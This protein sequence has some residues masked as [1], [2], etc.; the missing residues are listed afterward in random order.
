M[1]ANQTPQAKFLSALRKMAASGEAGFEGFVRDCLQESL[2]VRFCLM[3]SGPQDGADMRSDGPANLLQVAVEGKRYGNATPLPTEQIQLKI[4]S[5]AQAAAGLDLWVLATTRAISAT[6]RAKFAE[7]GDGQGV[8]TA[9]LDATDGANRPSALDLLAANAPRAFAKHFPA[10]AQVGPW[11][12]ALRQEEDFPERLERVL[13]PFRRTD[14]GYAAAREASTQWLV[15]AMADEATARARL[16]SF[17]GL[18]AEGAIVI[19][20]MGVEELLDTWLESGLAAPLAILG[21]EGVGK[22]WSLLGWWRRRMREGVDKLPLTLMVAA[23]A[24][25]SVGDV[26]GPDLIARLLADRFP[27][28]GQEFWRRRLALWAREP[29]AAPRVLLVID[30]LNQQPEFAKWH[31]I[32]QPLFDSDWNGLF[33]AGVTCRTAWWEDDLKALPTVSPGFQ[34]V[35]V[36]V[37]NEAELEQILERFGLARSAFSPEMQEILSIPRYCQLAI[38]RRHELVDSGDITIERL[39]YEDWRHRIARVGSSLCP[40]E[41]EFR[42]FI[43]ELG[44]NFRSALDGEAPTLSRREMIE[45]LDRDMGRGEPALRI[46]LSEIVDGNW[47]QRAKD[48]SRRFTLNAR[49]VPFA[50]ALALH[51]ELGI[52]EPTSA[53]D[54]LATF[55]DPLRGTDRGT[56]ILRTAVTIALLDPGSAQWIFTLLIDTWFNQQNFGQADATALGHLA[57][58]APE[59]FIAFA[60]RLWSGERHHVRDDS[61]LIEALVR[62]ARTPSFRKGL[63]ETLILWLSRVE[64]NPRRLPLGDRGSEVAL[65]GLSDAMDASAA[66]WA[67]AQIRLVGDGGIHT[68]SVMRHQGGGDQ[69]RLR[70]FAAGV[71]SFLPRAD[72]ATCYVAWALSRAVEQDSSE[73]AMDWCLRVNPVDPVAGTASIFETATSL[74]RS[75]VPVVA[76]TGLRLLDALATPAAGAVAADL[77]ATQYVPQSLRGLDVSVDGVVTSVSPH[78]GGQLG[79]FG[80]LGGDALLPDRTLAQPVLETLRRAADNF[81]VSDY[82]AS[83]RSRSTADIDFALTEAALARWAPDRLAAIV[84]RAYG[85]AAARMTTPEQSVDD[86]PGIGLSSLVDALGIYWP[87]LGDFEMNEL[88]PVVASFLPAALERDGKT[89]PWL[90]LQIPRLY[91]LTAAEQIELLASDPR[92]P[93]FF[94]DD[95]GVLTRPEPGDFARLSELVTG[96]WGVHWLGYLFFVDQEGMPD[97]FGALYPHVGSEDPIARRRALRILR[98]A[99]SV[100]RYR[101]LVESGWRWNAQMDADEGAFGS[102]VLLHASA[103]INV[104]DLEGRVDPEVWGAILAE[105]PDDDA[106]LER[107]TGYVID[108]VRRHR[109]PGGAFG[110]S[111]W[112]NQDDAVRI[113]V[114]RNG[115]RIIAAIE[116][117]IADDP[118]HAFGFDSFPIV[119]LLTALCVVL[120]SEGA[121]LWDALWEPYL[122]SSWTLSKFEQV[123]FAGS[124]ESLR[125]LQDRVLDTGLSDADVETVV[126]GV[127]ENGHEVWLLEHL[128]RLLAGASAGEIAKGLTIARF[129]DPSPA[130]D[131]AWQRIDSMA[132]SNWLAKIRDQAR[133]EYDLGRTAASSA[134]RFRATSDAD[135]ALADLTLF[136]HAADAGAF[137]ALKRSVREGYGDLSPVARVFWS[138]WE[139][140]LKA[141]AKKNSDG[142]DNRYLFEEPPKLTHHPWRS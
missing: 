8:A 127:H 97:D 70:I 25:A 59:R 115:E 12:D 80:L 136:G 58:A 48:G 10:L 83:G 124:D 49:Y 135:Q 99:P 30:G 64:L 36:P 39:I 2:S 126:S 52:A 19:P 22:T 67:G 63:R 74:A 103:R 138:E 17:A 57:P 77:G 110:G 61:V 113:T 123:P 26:A 85:T 102:L 42:A 45:A 130:A 75:S 46:A 44:L 119:D 118:Q 21:D 94:E 88:Q 23:S 134:E 92:G 20:R 137:E 13:E 68:I 90:R 37:F 1:P 81:D 32:I 60:E 122:A 106:A 35:Q 101:W 28:R 100:Q 89:D 9:V 93:N 133:R 51:R 15:T 56:A 16:D 116:A 18:E 120:P 4:V 50:L 114:A 24:I 117:L 125:S 33:A 73:S 40:S 96:E 132:L 6:D 86:D 79:D 105:H 98:Y 109:F 27:I 38:R 84:R 128:N 29:S 108:E 5:A 14:V 3:K 131:A 62:A 82:L 43:T 65:R 76:A 11:L 47:M 121:R 91:G 140:K 78:R 71:L 111:H 87:L 139:E 54:R 31:Q 41:E 107:F 69:K 53:P 72:F 129:L 34:P 66:E 7:T 55:M 95:V 112:L 142:R 104:P 141:A